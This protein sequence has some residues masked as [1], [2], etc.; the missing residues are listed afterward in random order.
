MNQSRNDLQV[1][2]LDQS[3][4]FFSQAK[5]FVEYSNSEAPSFPKASNKLCLRVYTLAGQ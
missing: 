2:I 1:H 5:D 3:T 4:P